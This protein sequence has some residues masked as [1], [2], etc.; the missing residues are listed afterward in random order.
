MPA[1]SKFAAE[2]EG[3]IRA[4]VREEVARALGH[5]PPPYGLTQD[6]DDEIRQKVAETLARMRAARTP[7]RRR[8]RKA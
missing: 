6:E 3:L 7:Q 2:I 4:I 5:D 1:A 8:R